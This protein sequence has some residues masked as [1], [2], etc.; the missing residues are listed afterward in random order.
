ME[1]INSLQDLLSF[2][3]KVNEKASGQW[4]WRGQE[5]SGWSLK[6]KVFRNENF[7]NNEKDRLLRFKKRAGIRHSS[8]PN[9]DQEIEWLFLMQ[10]YGLPTRLL[11]WT[12]SPLIACFFAVREIENTNGGE[13]IA[14]QPYK[15]NIKT[16]NKKALLM[17][18]DSVSLE[19]INNAYTGKQDD[20]RVIAIRPFEVDIRQMVQLSEFT[21]HGSDNALEEDDEGTDA[22]LYRISISGKYKPKILEELKQLGIRESIIFPDLDHLTKEISN[23]DFIG[24]QEE[25]HEYNERILSTGDNMNDRYRE[26]STG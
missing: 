7:M 20:Q 4:W 12:E 8:V 11:D 21:I 26:S 24:L 2:V 13:I 5:E 16:I 9:Q 14:L 22:F 10:H 1:T 19:L 23:T 25:P 6:P 3:Y 17:P 18:E 15:L